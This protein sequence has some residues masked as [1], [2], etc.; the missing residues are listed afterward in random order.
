MN[1]VTI[2]SLLRSIKK[3]CRKTGYPMLK[4]DLLEAFLIAKNKRLQEVCESADDMLQGILTLTAKL[5]KP[6]MCF[7]EI[8]RYAIKLTATDS[9]I[10]KYNI[11][12]GALKV[13]EFQ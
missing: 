3:H 13:G 2:E 10:H 8:K 6:S 11:K 12:V 9:V 5:G 1:E 7:G 4:F